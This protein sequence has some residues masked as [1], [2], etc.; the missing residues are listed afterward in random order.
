M[1]QIEMDRRQG[2][3]SAQGLLGGTKHEQELLDVIGLAVS[4]KKEKHAGMGELENMKNRP[5]ILI[6][7]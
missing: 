6:G 7:G 5:M 3:T 4:R 1:K 2:I